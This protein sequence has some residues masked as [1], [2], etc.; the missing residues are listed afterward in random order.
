MGEESAQGALAGKVVEI[1]R[2]PEPVYCPECGAPRTYRVERK[3]FLQ[4]RVFPILG[5]FPWQCR[6]CGAEVILRRRNRR[7]K[8]HSA[9]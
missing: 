4:R 2:K 7:W 1:E 9:V 6:N 8:R 5:F 3:G